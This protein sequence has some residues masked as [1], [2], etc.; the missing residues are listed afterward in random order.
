MSIYLSDKWVWDFWFAQDGADYHIFYL[1]APRALGDE[2]LRH[3]H[4][5]IGH[6][7]SSDLQHWQV[8]P[9]ALAPSVEYK[10]VFDSYT[11]WTGSIIHYRGLWYM[12]YTGGNRVEKGRIQ[13]VGLAT[14]IDLITWEKHPSNPLIVADS[15]WYDLIDLDIW[16]EQ[17]W[18]DP[19]VFRHNGAFHALITGRANHGPVDG[20]G[21]I[22][23]ARSLD[24]VQWEVL[25]PITKPGLFGHMEVPQLISANGC[26]YLLFSCGSKLLSSQGR[27]RFKNKTGSYYLCGEA[28]LGPFRYL[29]DEPLIGD[30]NGSLYSGKFVQGPDDDWY[31][32][33]FNNYDKDGNFVG[34]ITDPMPVHIS[35][36]GRLNVIN[37]II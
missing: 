18:R 31:L 14:S 33:A 32:M 37:Q 7:V 29:S 17:A 30:E 19:W 35:E 34:E 23:H 24:L 26:Y 10:D 15:Q 36:E 8:L 6:A 28:P 2:Y 22:A 9:D 5:S 16:H 21:V 3:W 13:R 27:N 20:R 11:T 12:F 1:Q 4:V 25:P